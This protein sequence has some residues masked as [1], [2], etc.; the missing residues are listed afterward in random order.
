MK[1]MRRTGLVAVLA[2]L[3]VVGLSTFVPSA[4]AD[5][6]VITSTIDN[7]TPAPGN[8][9]TMSIT[10]TNNQ[11]TGVSFVYLSVNP[12]YATAQQSPDLHYTVTSCTGDVSWCPYDAG[13]DKGGASLHYTVPIPPGATR[14]AVLT[15]Q[16]SP[17][18]GCLSPTTAGNYV[19]GFYYYF[20]YEFTDA[21]GNFASADGE[22]GS[23]AATV[24]CG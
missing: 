21:S 1:K 4:S 11:T 20:Y 5:T 6:P 8:T 13:V 22:T 18:S 16:V 17:T 3:F 9:V 23:P 12:D 7:P 19:I 14:T 24:T 15:Y 2:I 10:F